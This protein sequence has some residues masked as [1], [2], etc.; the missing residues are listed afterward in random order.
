MAS[1]FPW[2]DLPIALGELLRSGL[3]GVVE[4]VIAA[5]RAEVPE[6]DQP[7]E[8]EFGM[9]ISRGVTVAVILQSSDCA[10]ALWDL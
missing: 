6:Y 10:P 5:V 4:E 9:L 8:G 3:S 1:T 2:G 7:L